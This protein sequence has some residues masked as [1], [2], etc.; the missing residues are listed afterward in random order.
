MK[1]LD[2][3]IE[4]MEIETGSRHEPSDKELFQ[5]Q[6]LGLEALKLIKWIRE[7]HIPPPDFQ[8]PGETKEEEVNYK[9]DKR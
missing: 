8:L 4:I 5:A 6:M 9:R 1:T 7:G 3:A 2:E